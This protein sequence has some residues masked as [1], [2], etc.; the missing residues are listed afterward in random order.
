MQPRRGDSSAS[1]AGMDSTSAAGSREPCPHSSR[2]A[3]QDDRL[4]SRGGTHSQDLQELES[5]IEHRLQIVEKAIRLQMTLG[6][7]HLQQVEM[8][9]ES[10][11]LSA[12]ARGPLRRLR[13]SRNRALHSSPVTGEGE[14]ATTKD[15]NY[16]IEK[17]TSPLAAPVEH[18]LNQPSVQAQVFVGERF[19][20]EDD[21][22]PD[23]PP[24]EREPVSQ[25]GARPGQVGKLPTPEDEIEKARRLLRAT[26]SWVPIT[27][28]GETKN[29][30]W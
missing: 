27:L 29:W 1:S 23:T 18:A 4:G 10:F 15:N 21:D 16:E 11:G 24:F 2:Q 5:D 20:T 8:A 28:K 19:T 12:A 14:R 26:A 30:P 22:V 17:D 13:R 6:A 25:N 7:T 9:P 3:P